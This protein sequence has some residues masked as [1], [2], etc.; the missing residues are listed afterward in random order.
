[1]VQISP[2]VPNAASPGKI[3]LEHSAPIKY[4]RIVF[5]RSRHHML[6]PSAILSPYSFPREC[7]IMDS[8]VKALSLLIFAFFLISTL[9]T[10]CGGGGGLGGG[11]TTG[12]SSDGTQNGKAKSPV[13]TPTGGSF[14]MAQSVIISSETSGA[15]VYYTVDGADPASQGSLY[16]K[17]LQLLRNATVKALVRGSGLEDSAITS[18]DFTFPPNTTLQTSLEVSPTTY[19]DIPLNGADW[20][21]IKLNSGD[22]LRVEVSFSGGSPSLNLFDSSDAPLN[23]SVT[24]DA[25]SLK[26]AYN[27]RSPGYYSFSI[28]EARSAY[29]KSRLQGITYTLSIFTNPEGQVAAPLF[30]PGDGEYAFPLSI[31]MTSSTP[32]AAIYYTTDGS[33]PS[34]GSQH[35]TGPVVLTVPGTVKAYAMKNG[36]TDSSVS[37][38]AYT[39]LIEPSPSPNPSPTSSPTP[40]GGGGGGTPVPPGTPATL[41]GYVID[42]VG[43]AI[44]G[45]NVSLDYDITVARNAPRAQFTGRRGV[46][47]RNAFLT[48]VSDEQGHYIFT[49]VPPGYY[50]L[51]ATKPSYDP[52]IMKVTLLPGSSV[53]QNLILTWIPVYDGHCDNLYAIWGT[54]KYNVYAVGAMGAIVKYA[55]S[56]LINLKSKVEEDL[57][58]VYGAS[59]GSVVYAGGDNN[60]LLSSRDGGLT[61]TT[62]IFSGGTVRQIWCDASGNNLYVGTDSN[63]YKRSGSGW[64]AIGHV[65]SI[66]GSADGVRVFVMGAVASYGLYSYT[67][68]RSD[69]GGQFNGIHTFTQNGRFAYCPVYY[70][71]NAD[72]LMVSMLTNQSACSL[73]STDYGITWGSSNLPADIYIGWIIG[74]PNASKIIVQGNQSAHGFHRSTNRC[75]SWDSS[76][77]YGQ[78]G[79]GAWISP[80]GVDIF[81]AN[82]AGEI[83]HYNDVTAT[84]D[85]NYAGDTPTL[86]SVCVLSDS[87]VCAVGFPRDAGS[88]LTR[89]GMRYDGVSWQPSSLTGPT[90]S[91]YFYMCGFLDTSSKPVYLCTDSVSLA[92]SIDGGDTWQSIPGSDPMNCPGVMNLW[93]T[94]DG[95]TIDY[96]AGDWSIPGNTLYKLH[97]SF[98][99]GNTFYDCQG[100]SWDNFL[101]ALWGTH[102]GA[103]IYHSCDNFTSIYRYSKSGNLMNA[104]GPAALPANYYATGIWG[105]SDGTHIY[106]ACQ[107]GHPAFAPSNGLLC[108]STDYGVTWNPIPIGTMGTGNPF[109]TI[110]GTSAS[111]IFVGGRYIY[112]FDG[113]SWTQTQLIIGPPGNQQTITRFDCTCIHG[114]SDGRTVYAVG[115]GGKI[116]RLTQ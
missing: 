104:D 90:S 10:G 29:L 84:G 34:A 75:Q 96:L 85:H 49:N 57:R 20:Y 25:S 24:G 65:G 30:A 22:V 23:A 17:P 13:I 106:A 97:Y 93:C 50:L 36:L 92:R 33:D 72:L 73:I 89:L 55:G 46:T 3:C 109:T 82:Y 105:T 54:S 37:S 101:Y 45:A 88:G 19:T 39:A 35:Y 76:V 2:P 41:Q 94:A 52:I 7:E 11:G 6:F 66:F 99:G 8:K 28:A 91:P 44:A 79:I 47:A 40:G 87:A 62:M 107:D 71:S 1:M 110:W 4:N 77:S 5:R 32:D 21:K 86:N 58:C 115:K 83:Y 59:D 68:Y 61:W 16:T 80:D 43:N 81:F 74:T 113:H 31:A 111:N 12:S 38:V 64:T 60:T 67:L 15:T 103:R 98:D 78:G 48:T 56:G 51:T 100:P 69:N 116:Y 26:L 27:V 108:D 42:Q 112:H 63:V 114:T 14:S 53:N 70:T 18:A 95:A 9:L 102:D